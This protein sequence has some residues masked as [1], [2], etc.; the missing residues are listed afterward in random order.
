MNLSYLKSLDHFA[1]DFGSETEGLSGM[2]WVTYPPI[3][4]NG[5]VDW[6]PLATVFGDGRIVICVRLLAVL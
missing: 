3:G 2:V 5:E 6:L 4:W 1:Q